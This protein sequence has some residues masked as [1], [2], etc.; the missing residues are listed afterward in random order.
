MATNNA[1]TGAPPKNAIANPS[2]G[3]YIA[4]I[5][6]VASHNP[7]PFLSATIGTIASTLGA[8]VPP[9]PVA[10]G[11]GTAIVAATS[12]L[13][14]NPVGFN[15]GDLDQVCGA[16][17]DPQQPAPAPKPVVRA[18]LTHFKAYFLP[19]LPASES[20]TA[21]WP[22]PL[23]LITKLAKAN[24]VQ[25]LQLAY[26]ELTKAC[27]DI[28]VNALPAVDKWVAK[29]FQS[30]QLPKDT[31]QA[32][33]LDSKPSRAPPTVALYTTKVL[34]FPSAPV[35]DTTTSH[36]TTSLTSPSSPSTT[37]HARQMPPRLSRNLKEPISDLRAKV[38]SPDFD[39][40]R[41]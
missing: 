23:P 25:D 8:A 4:A 21:A 6:P 40:H 24:T 33:S 30:L 19:P 37:T 7:T 2:L 9:G 15:P 18:P 36:T 22:D 32:R 39:L 26:D 20:F 1:P 38:R 29:A 17:R 3:A 11:A 35:S 34:P 14:D 31:V 12:L 27:K 13:R 28:T 41:H 5:S 16:D 10:P